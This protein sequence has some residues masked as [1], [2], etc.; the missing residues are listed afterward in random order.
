[1]GLVGVSGFEPLS[2]GL[3]VRHNKPLYDTPL[4]MVG[5]EEYDSPVSRF[6]AECS[7]QLSYTPIGET[8]G[9]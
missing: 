2:Y 6:V 3:R 1:M 7:I 4:K 8:P 5:V 9:G